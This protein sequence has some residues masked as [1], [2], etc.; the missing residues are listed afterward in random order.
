MYIPSDPDHFIITC[1]KESMISCS[2]A[3]HR[4]LAENNP[5]AINAV[6]IIKHYVGKSHL[7]FKRK[8]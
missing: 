8:L 4:N 3:V 1:G 5:G 7:G 6:Y 2:R